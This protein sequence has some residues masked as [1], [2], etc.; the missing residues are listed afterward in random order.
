MGHK[1]AGVTSVWKYFSSIKL[2][3]ND[4]Q[5]ST[6]TTYRSAPLCLLKPVWCS[7]G[8]RS[9]LELIT[10]NVNSP[11][12]RHLESHWPPISR[13]YCIIIIQYHHQVTTYSCALQSI[14]VG[15]YPVKF[16]I[17]FGQ[18]LPAENIW[19]ARLANVSSNNNWLLFKSWR[20]EFS[21]LGVLS[22]QAE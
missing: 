6:L 22:P 9:T 15:K 5:A 13:A 17:L 7:R 20:E 18:E 12:W 1:R 19:E 16:K 4:S 2:S 8:I 3:T 21:V 10:I 14:K 11:A